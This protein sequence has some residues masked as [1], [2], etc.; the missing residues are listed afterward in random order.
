MITTARPSSIRSA[1]ADAGRASSMSSWKRSTMRANSAP[2]D[3]SRRSTGSSRRMSRT[4]HG[5]SFCASALRRRL[6]A[7]SAPSVLR[8]AAAFSPTRTSSTRVKAAQ[9]LTTRV[10]TAF[11]PRSALSCSWVPAPPTTRAEAALTTATTTNPHEARA[12]GSTMSLATGRPRRSSYATMPANTPLTRKTTWKVGRY[13]GVS[14]VATRSTGAA[15]RKG[16]TAH[17]D[18]RRPKCSRSPIH[19]SGSKHSISAEAAA[20]SI[21]SSVCCPASHR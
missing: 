9:V 18:A 21:C 13:Q 2:V 17:Q 10:P 12:S 1:S 14:V 7:R 15:T 19:T 16:I 11:M 4:D 20:R 6:R 8:P 5:W 3:A